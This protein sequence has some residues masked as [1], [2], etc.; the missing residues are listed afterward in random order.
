MLGAQL[1][2]QVDHVVA[3]VA[4][5]GDLHLA[6]EELLIARVKR[7]GEGLRLRAGVVDQVLPLGLVAGGGQHA[8][9]RVADGQAAAGAH[10]QRPHRVGADELHLHAP[11]LA[12]GHVAE[13]RALGQD[14]LHLAGEPAVAQA[15]VDEARRRHRHL[16][17]SV[18]GVDVLG[19]SLGDGER[20]VAGRARQLQRQAD[21]IVPVLLM[22]GALHRHV[23]EGDGRQ[24]AG[25]L[26]PNRRLGYQPTR[27]RA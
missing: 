9:Q 3:G 15:E 27:S 1:F 22:G 21:G 17:E 2:G 20:A 16:G 14:L 11:A 5:L 12:Q 18:A 24:V 8:R 7:G 6:P 25:F 23:G 10:V 19:D 13:A 4:T 26:R